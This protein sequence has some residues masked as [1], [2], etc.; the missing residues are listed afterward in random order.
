MANPMEDIVANATAAPVEGHISRGSFTVAQWCQHRQLSVSFF[1][2]LDQQGKA[3]ATMRIGRRRLISFES[4]QA[5]V[6]ANE[7]ASAAA[8]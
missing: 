6:R 3:P 8:A 7:A 4:D 5:W 1:Y 2:R